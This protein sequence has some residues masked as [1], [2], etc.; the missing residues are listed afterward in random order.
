MNQS[1]LHWKGNRKCQL[2]WIKISL[3]N[4][5]CI[6]GVTNDFSFT[7]HR[8]IDQKTKKIYERGWCKENRCQ[9]S[10]KIDDDNDCQEKWQHCTVG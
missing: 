1:K 8:S 9:L 3:S 2:N 6:G 5:D 10:G 7:L 4:F